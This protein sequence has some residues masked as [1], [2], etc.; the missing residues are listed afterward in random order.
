MFIAFTVRKFNL[1]IPMVALLCLIGVPL[2]TT[3][4]ASNLEDGVS[5]LA[6]QISKNMTETGKK[7][8]AVVEFSDL[9]GNVRA[10]G[11]FLAEEL[12]TELF[13]ISPGQFEVVERRQLMKVLD[14][15]KLTTSGLLDA[16]AMDSV[17]KILGIE[18]IA[19][20]SITDLGNNVKVNARMIGVD[21]AKVFAVARTSIP[22]IGIVAKM[23]DTIVTSGSIIHTIQE[24]TNPGSRSSVYTNKNSKIFHR[25]DCPELNTKGLVEFKSTQGAVK[26]GGMACRR[27][28]PSQGKSGSVQGNTATSV[29]S[30]QNNFLR[31]TL[32]SI[33]KSA[34]KRS[35]GW[36][37]N[38]VNLVFT[39]ENISNEDIFIA[40][41]GRHAGASLVGNQAVE[42]KLENLNG[43]N[44]VGPG[45]DR[46]LSE[47]SMF[48]PG[49][50]NTITITFESRQKSDET[51]FSFS[52][53]ML[54]FVNESKIR[55]SIGISNMRITQ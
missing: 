24:P 46:H 55:F 35:G 21:T 7:K 16:K 33:N 45:Y 34:A 2:S 31:V 1:I 52:A 40:L 32:E 10:L 30:F 15:Q 22:K 11:Q 18:A 13:L 19:T 28:N 49:S 53:N 36:V 50:K 26:A 41:Q 9:N 37:R 20:G 51:T 39:L 8:I 23:W 3:F 47:Y 14:E 27:C 38:R 48:N 29:P 4:A 6:Q 25:Y 5:E 17:G 43:I 12:I 42:W 54:R 44:P